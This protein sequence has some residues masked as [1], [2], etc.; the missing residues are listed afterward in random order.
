[1]KDRVN[2]EKYKKLLDDGVDC[3]ITN[4]PK[5]ATK[6]RDYYVKNKLTNNQKNKNELAE[7]SKEKEDML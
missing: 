5:E 4:Y 3:I 6:F 7:N 2:E 1:M